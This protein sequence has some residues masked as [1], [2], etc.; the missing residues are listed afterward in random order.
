MNSPER[1]SRLRRRCVIRIAA[2]VCISATVL[3]YTCSVDSG[4]GDWSQQIIH[5]TSSAAARRPTIRTFF[6]P[7]LNHAEQ[8]EQVEVWKRAWIKAGW[9]ARTLGIDDARRHPSY[10][11]LIEQ[12]DGLDWC[13][14]VEF[15]RM[16]YIR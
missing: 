8:A 15:Q 5:N 2:S 7:L 13:K 1:K 10:K 16:C 9:D 6:D 12:I 3:F 11:E 4:R 14:N